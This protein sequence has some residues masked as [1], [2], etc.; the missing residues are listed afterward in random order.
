M[1]HPKK[2]G[3]PGNSGK[4]WKNMI[5][6]EMGHSKNPGYRG[7]PEKTIKTRQPETYVKELNVKESGFQQLDRFSHPQGRKIPLH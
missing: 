2:T 1:Q 3:V 4:P 7:G 5:S 6:K